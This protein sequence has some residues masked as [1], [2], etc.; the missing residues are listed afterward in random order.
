[1]RPVRPQ[2]YL[3]EYACGSCA[4]LVRF[5]VAMHQCQFTRGKSTRGRSTRGK[6]TIGAMPVVVTDIARPDPA[7]VAILARNGVAT[8][9]EAQGRLGLMAEAL[10]PIY[11]PVSIAGPA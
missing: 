5:G 8:V 10:R 11:R 3:P 4:G 6:S 9:H 1:G 2:R 7:A